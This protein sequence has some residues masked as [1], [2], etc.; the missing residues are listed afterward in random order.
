MRIF[1][2]ICTIDTGIEKASNVLQEK[3]KNVSYIVSHQ[4]TDEKFKY[5]P[6]ELNRPDVV[7]S[8]I[9]GAGLSRNRNNALK[10]ADGDI[11]LIADDDVT[12]LPDSFQTILEVFKND[13]ELD[14]ACFKI[15]TYDNEPEYKNYPDKPYIL[16]KYNKHSVSSIE[17]AFRVNSIRKNCIYFDERFGL[18]SEQLPDAEEIVFIQDCM[19]SGLKVAYFP[20]YVVK[21]H[22]YNIPSGD[23]QFTSVRNRVRGAY[24]AR[25]FG[26]RSVPIALIELFLKMPSIIGNGRNPLFYAFERF[27][28]IY[29]I[30]KTNQRK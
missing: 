28:A 15:K 2:M 3:L 19:K 9:S 1:I 20:V 8:Q 27:K 16:T 17:I 13:P 7:V 21:H 14:V 25:V 4:I 12:Y 11:A 30:F 23:S 24:H 18:G 5:I 26:W 6:D 10:L 29:Y 22:Y